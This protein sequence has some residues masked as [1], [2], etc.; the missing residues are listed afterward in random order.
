M[1]NYTK[2]NLVGQGAFGSV[3]LC[4]RKTDKKLLIL[5]EIPMDAMTAEER[6]AARNEVQILKVLSH[7]NI[8]QYYE[9]FLD[10]T[11]LVIAMEYAQGGTLYQYLKKQTSLL[12]E[13]EVLHLFVQILTALQHIHA[14][15]ILHRDLKTENILLDRKSRVCKVSDFGISKVLT[16]K[17]KAMTVV[18]TPCYISPELCEG[19]AYNQKS[20]MWALGCM[21]YELI[22][23]RRAFEATNLP[24]LVN[25]ITK[26]HYNTNFPKLYSNPLMNL[27]KRLLSLNPD[28]RPCVVDIMAEPFI[29]RKLIDVYV[30]IG[31]VEV[32]NQKSSGSGKQGRFHHTSSSS[33]IDSMA[34]TKSQ[35][36]FVVY[37][38]GGSVST[39]MKLPLPYADTQIVQVDCGRTQKACVTENGR[40]IIWESSSTQALPGALEDSQNVPAFIPRFLEGQSGVC[41]KMVSC[42]DMHMACL[43]DRGILMTSGTGSNGCLGHGSFNDLNEPKIV[44]ALLSHEVIEIS[45]GSYHVLALTSDDEVF[46]WGS[47]DKGRLGLG[48]RQTHCTPQ[49]VSVPQEYEVKSVICGN[50]S[51][52]ILTK[53]KKMLS[54]GN[55]NHNKLGLD[56]VNNG[57]VLKETS[58]SLKLIPVQTYP[59][60]DVKINK[61]SLGMQ[62]SAMIT[63]DGDLLLV[64][65]NQ[66]GQLGFPPNDS[67]RHS[68]RIPR[69]LTQDTE[70]KFQAVSCGGTFTVAITDNGKVLTWG[71]TSRGQLGRSTSGPVSPEPQE[72]ALPG[73]TKMKIVSLSASHA[74][75]LLAVSGTEKND[76]DLD[77][78][79]RN[80]WDT[81][82]WREEGKKTPQK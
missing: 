67:G 36:H 25:K 49:P 10:G 12:G 52:V 70:T 5:K 1:E 59:F 65:N 41:V 32:K 77:T 16:T 31:A 28:L 15:N 45:C 46:A 9:N 42:G 76:P 50:D 24:A 57:E 71:K 74:F 4:S 14:K 26:A 56:V 54:C 33:S 75:T 73:I 30:D 78:K 43:T 58:E 8:I 11:R 37:C 79:F 7:P 34:S 53:D 21:L 35:E 64:G 66:F 51:S 20:D 29:M 23:L 47:G 40:L 6:G 2:I 63:D 19:K 3:Y 61:V 17:T 80:S 60:T 55:N 69:K 39:P 68:M 18:G 22:A 81:N 38:W 48:D 82:T 72:V 62:H 27:L 44:E 13:E